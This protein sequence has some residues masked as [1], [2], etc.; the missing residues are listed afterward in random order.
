VRQRSLSA[1]S[2]FV[3]FGAPN[4]EALLSTLKEQTTA[5]KVMGSCGQEQADAFIKAQSV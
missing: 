2:T 3:T 5:K 1:E 4:G